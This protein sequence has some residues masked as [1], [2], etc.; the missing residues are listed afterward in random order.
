MR[1]LEAGQGNLLAEMKVEENHINHF[2]M[3]HGGVI[4]TLADTLSTTAFLTL[5]VKENDVFTG[6]KSA[7]VRLD[8][9]F[10][11]PIL[12][13]S[14]VVIKCSTINQ[15]KTLAYAQIDFT[16]RVSGKMLAKGNH[17][18]FIKV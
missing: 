17:L 16:D 5:H 2:K 1:I 10:L 18:M 9:T 12:L 6:P 4:T 14:V 11:K 15:G 7:S 8:V 3:M 13:D